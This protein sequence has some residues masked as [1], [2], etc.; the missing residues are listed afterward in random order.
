MIEV[1]PGYDD[2]KTARI[3]Q[4]REM[5]SVEFLD[6]IAPFDDCLDAWLSNRVKWERDLMT[7][8]NTTDM[9]LERYPVFVGREI[10]DHIENS[11]R[12]LFWEH[13]ASEY[14]K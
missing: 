8:T 3:A 4:L 9:F 2:W 1:P 10:N 11:K 14:Y 6:Q 12:I 13:I 5:L 7:L